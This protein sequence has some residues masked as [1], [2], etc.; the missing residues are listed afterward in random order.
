MRVGI[1]LLSILIAVAIILMVSFSGPH[2][3]YVPTVLNAG[4]NAKSQAQQIAGR[5]ENDIPVRESIS[6]DEDTQ[7][8]RLHGL[9]VKGI[10]PT[11]PMAT[12]YGL[13]PGDVIVEIGPFAVKDSTDPEDMKN[14]VYQSYT[15][16]YPLVIERNGQ[17]LTLTPT[18]P[19]SQAHPGLF[20]A[21]TPASPS[22]SP[23]S[24]PT[25]APIGVPQNIPTH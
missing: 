12:A 25:P 5:D 2:G 4:N 1:G 20:P 15:N 14:W 11:G 17:S 18:T 13:L 24:S 8:G 23:P 22:G 19:L 16:N 6:L 9:I 21:A 3:G 7:N 10:V